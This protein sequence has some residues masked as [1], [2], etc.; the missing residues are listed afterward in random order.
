MGWV[1]RQIACSEE[2]VTKI[3]RNIIRPPV[4]RSGQSYYIYLFNAPLTMYF[5]YLFIYLFID[6]FIYLFICLFINLFSCLFIYLFVYIIIYLFICIFIYLFIS[7]I[8]IHRSGKYCIKYKKVT[9]YNVC[10]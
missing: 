5:I 1:V 4:C 6:L 10:L 9:K 2:G 3:E 8:I 7:I